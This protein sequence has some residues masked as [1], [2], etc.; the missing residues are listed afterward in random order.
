MLNASLIFFLL[1]LGWGRVGQ[2]G[3]PAHQVPSNGAEPAAGRVLHGDLGH[4]RPH[5]H[6]HARVWPATVLVVQ[7]LRRAVVEGTPGVSVEQLLYWD[8]GRRYC[9]FQITQHHTYCAG[10]LL[11]RATRTS[12]HIKF[13]ILTII[14][15]QHCSTTYNAYY[16]KRSIQYRYISLLGYFKLSLQYCYNNYKCGVTQKKPY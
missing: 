13:F 7:I 6:I 11:V 4:R 15:I 3:R 12:S 16:W 10:H 8:S 5:G 2:D 1:L 14:H 9:T